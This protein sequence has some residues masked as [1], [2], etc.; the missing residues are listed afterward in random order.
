MS[1]EEREYP[2]LEDVDDGCGCTEIW[3]H[4]VEERE[5]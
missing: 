4:L 1:N 2:H 5:E 3:S